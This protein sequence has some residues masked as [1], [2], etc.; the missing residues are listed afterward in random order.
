[1]N[2]ASINGT[3]FPA[4]KRV[5]MVFVKRQQPQDGNER[6]THMQVTVWHRFA[7]RIPINL[8][9]MTKKMQLHRTMQKLHAQ[10]QQKARMTLTRQA[11]SPYN[12][13]LKVVSLNVS[14]DI[15]SLLH[16]KVQSQNLVWIFRRVGGI[17]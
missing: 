9:L 13:C 6:K 10:R 11:K 7:H 5:L 17:R 15:K 16:R 2:K 8:R 12:A 14:Q 4:W 3:L 1:M